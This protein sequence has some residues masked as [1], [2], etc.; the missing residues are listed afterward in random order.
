MRKVEEYNFRVL[1][2]IFTFAASDYLF[3]IKINE[4]V[5]F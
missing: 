4:K 5:K 3:V 2:D 1:K